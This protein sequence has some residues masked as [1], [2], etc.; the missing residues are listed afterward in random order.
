MTVKEFEG[1]SFN[2]KVNFLKKNATLV[3]SLIRGEMLISLYWSNELIFEVF[4]VK[5]TAS[6]YE[7]KGFD[8]FKYAA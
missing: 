3:H 8:R 6:I 1:L 7:I 2:E 4:H 5:D